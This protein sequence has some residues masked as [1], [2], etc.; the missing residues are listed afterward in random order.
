[1]L[2]VNFYTKLRFSSAL[3][4]ISKLFSVIALCLLSVFPANFVPLFQWIK[5]V[6]T[7]DS[8]RSQV[9]LSEKM[10]YSSSM[11]VGMSL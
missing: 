10:P 1:M 8:S 2:L 9:K 6:A 3:T 7:L 5:T 11:R 4:T